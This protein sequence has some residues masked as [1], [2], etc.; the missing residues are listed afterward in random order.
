MDR[1]PFI[2]ENAPVGGMVPGH[3]QMFLLLS[4]EVSCP[5]CPVLAWGNIHCPARN[6]PL[7][8]DAMQP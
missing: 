2:E 3:V 6:A 5:W 1:K 7:L 4:V 8:S